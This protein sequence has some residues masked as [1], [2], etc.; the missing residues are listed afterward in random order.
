M[1]PGLTHSTLRT[2]LTLLALALLAG[3]GDAK[4]QF[5]DWAIARERAS[6]DLQEQQIEAAGFT[7]ATLQTGGPRKEKTLVMIHGFGAN[8]DNWVR[9]AGYL[10]DDYHLVMFDLPGH[11]DSSKP[12]SRRYDLDD[13]V[14][15][16]DAILGKLG[17]PGA[18]FLGNSMGGAIAAL[19]AARHPEKVQGLVLFSP[20]GIYEVESELGKA[21]REGRNPLIA[22]NS[23]EFESLIQ[24]AMEKPPFMPWP[25]TDVLASRSIADQPIKERIFADLRTEPHAY[26]FRGELQTVT[27]PSLI[28]WGKYD[29]VIDVGNAEPFADLLPNGRALI[30]ADIGHVPMLEDPEGSARLTSDFIQDMLVKAGPSTIQP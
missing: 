23:E 7:V 25:V 29:R 1:H 8:K 15:N 2:L 12:L 10:K 27:A 28:V 19:Y 11:G 6:A 13:Q 9:M 18:V 22:R 17:I 16:V 24:F 14:T 5:Y 20:A 4:S 3:C 26:D 21:L 30:L